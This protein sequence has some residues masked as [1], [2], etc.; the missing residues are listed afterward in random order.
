MAFADNS[1]YMGSNGDGS[2]IGA[3]YEEEFSNRFEFSENRIAKEDVQRFLLEGANWTNRF[4]H[5]V[6]VMDEGDAMRAHDQ[7]F[8]YARV[9]KTRAWVVIDEDE[10]GPVLECW[11]F[12]NAQRTIYKRLV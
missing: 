11:K 10:N 12:K 7:G 9:L 2:I 8:R 4:P 5:K 6:W 3:F 1:T